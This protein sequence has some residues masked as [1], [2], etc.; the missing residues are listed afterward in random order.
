MVCR[1]AVAAELIVRYVGMQQLLM[2]SREVLVYA[3]ANSAV[4]YAL[5]AAGALGGAA[6]LLTGAVLAVHVRRLHAHYR[7]ERAAALS[8][9]FGAW[10][11]ME[12]VREAVL[13]LC[14]AAGLVAYLTAQQ[15]GIQ[16]VASA[17]IA[18]LLA[19]GLIGLSRS[20]TGVQ[21][22]EPAVVPMAQNANDLLG[23]KRGRSGPRLAVAA[24]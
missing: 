18:W 20:V 14:A 3:R 16:T 17:S 22:P 6:L 9:G 24:A 7:D 10:A 21:G 8:L 13:P 23:G 5:L 2:A 15:F 11:G 1:L 19:G 4:L 12:V